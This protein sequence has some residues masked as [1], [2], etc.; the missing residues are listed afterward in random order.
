MSIAASPGG[1]GASPG[2][3]YFGAVTSTKTE[4]STRKIDPRATYLRVNADPEALAASALDLRE[5]NLLPGDT[6]RLR[7]LGGFRY[8]PPSSAEL[9]TMVGV[10][11]SS[12]TLL[13]PSSLHRVP[14]AVAA[15]LAYLTIPTLEGV[16][17]TDIAED[18]LIDDTLV[19]VPP[20]ATHLFLSPVDFFFG[21]NSDADGDY[22]LE[23]TK[24]LY[25]PT[26]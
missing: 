20:E 7:R 22:K 15:G 12:P 17:P 19:C 1:G 24:Y 23:I 3:V 16:L 25:E 11:S 8:D 10:F 13:G 18:F 9:R 21:D 2:S 5:L 4:I 6:I 14:A 26:L